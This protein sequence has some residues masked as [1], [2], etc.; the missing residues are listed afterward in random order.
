MKKLT[1]L[2]LV[3]AV[4]AA[5]APPT[6]EIVEKEVVVEKPVVQTVVVE[7]EV[8]VEKPVVQT[9]VVEKVVKET[10]VVDQK[11]GGTFVV[12]HN[13][14]AEGSLDPLVSRGTKAY[15]YNQHLFDPLARLD[16]ET[17]APAP[18]LAESWEV[19]A[20]SRSTV[21][22]LRKDV[23][24]QDGTPFN[25]EAAKFNFD[26]IQE[27]GPEGQRWSGLGGDTFIGAEV[28]DEFTVKLSWTEPQGGWWDFQEWE[29]GM[30][31][32]TAV[33]EYG[34]KYGLDVVVGTG[35]FKLVEYVEGSQIVMEKNPD[36]N[37][38]SPVYKH[39]GPPYV[40]KL[41]IRA[42]REHGTRLAAL[43]AGEVDFVDGRGVEYM[44]M[45]MASRR[46]FKVQLVPKA[47]TSVILFLNVQRPPFDDIRVRQAFSHAIDRQTLLLAPRWSNVG[48]AA[49]TTIAAYNWPGGD[50]EEFKAYNYLYDPERAAAL[51]EEASW[52]D[53]DGD[54][55]REKDGQRLSVEFV[56]SSESI[57]EVEP[58]EG[59]VAKVGIEVNW[60][61]LDTQAYFNAMDEQLFDVVLQSW[62]GSG[63]DKG[64]AVFRCDS[65][66]NVA[67]LCDPELDKAIDALNQTLDLEK[68]TEAAAKAERI[69]LE[70]AGAIPLVYQ[71]YPWIMKDDVMDIFMP[72]DSWAR[73]Y[74]VWL[75]RETK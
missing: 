33:K 27:L 50:I 60:Q 42:I 51:L 8:V 36:Y 70:S 16:P 46:G 52:V 22:H 34:D 59:M 40:D 19:S 4:L 62:S 11:Q 9:V 71:V 1:A 29:I 64:I 30:Q 72:L 20:D 25:A 37:W 43:E 49:Y 45:D 13:T 39:Q 35:P 23:K 17:G 54:G 6:P 26:R 18:A 47:G 21:F 44:V 66:D 65:P 68:R 63:L 14:V 28:V 67:E 3:L 10:V 7:K 32:P 61:Q 56:V 24:F 31:S 55:I 48:K 73:F 75:D 58:I 38:G 2:L 41:I 57:T 15:F 53:A 5:C 12:G 69:I 74:D